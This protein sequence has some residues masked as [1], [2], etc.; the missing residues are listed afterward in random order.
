VTLEQGESVIFT[1]DCR[2]AVGK[3]G[4]QR[5]HLWH[6]VSRVTSGRRYSLGVIFHNSK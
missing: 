1:T 3:R 2:P 5:V 6:G 4:Y